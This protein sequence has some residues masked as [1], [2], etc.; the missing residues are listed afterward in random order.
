MKAAKTN[1]MEGGRTSHFERERN[2]NEFIGVSYDFFN[3]QIPF[4]SPSSNSNQF[5]YKT[6]LFIRS[7]FKITLFIYIMSVQTGNTEGI[8]HGGIFVMSPLPSPL[9]PSPPLPLSFPPHP[10]KPSICV[11]SI[12]ILEVQRFR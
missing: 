4:Q 7:N 2:E 12:L 11:I 3:Y 8:F 5:I 6:E 1:T 10:S 9:S